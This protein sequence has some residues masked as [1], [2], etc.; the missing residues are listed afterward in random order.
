MHQS[1][2]CAR[3]RSFAGFVQPTPSAA[4]A[5]NGG[6][7]QRP[8]ASSACREAS[9]AAERDAKRV[10]SGV[11]GCPRCDRVGM[12]AVEVVQRDAVEGDADVVSSLLQLPG[13]L[14]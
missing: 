6:G 2:N 12:R 8:D 4:E 7:G 13:R 10:F 5:I 14:I 11:N 9:F 1:S 3:T